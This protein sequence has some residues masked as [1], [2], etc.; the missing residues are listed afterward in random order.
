MTILGINYLNV[1]IT[2]LLVIYVFV[3]VFMILLVL[4]RQLCSWLEMLD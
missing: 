4:M 3:C 1:S 2:A